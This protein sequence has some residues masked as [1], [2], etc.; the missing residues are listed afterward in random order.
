MLYALTVGCYGV[1][2]LALI[3]HSL[4]GLREAVERQTEVNGVSE[5][6]QLTLS[7]VDLTIALGVLLTQSPYPGP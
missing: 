2:V 4:S 7:K 3:W 1:R 6:S 5:L